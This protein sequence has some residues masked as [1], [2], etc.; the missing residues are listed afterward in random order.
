ML[1]KSCL[2]NWILEFGNNKSRFEI[3]MTQHVANAIYIA[4]LIE[5]ICS[6]LNEAPLPPEGLAANLNTANSERQNQ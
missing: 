5:L 1:E 3:E 6:K 4:S 2:V